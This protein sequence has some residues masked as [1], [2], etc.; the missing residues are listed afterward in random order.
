MQKD[1]NFYN[2]VRE[3]LNGL[4][5]STGHQLD[6]W[7]T[8]YAI[9]DAVH[10]NIDP[11]MSAVVRTEH[12]IAPQMLV[13]LRE[14]VN[15]AP[16]IPPDMGGGENLFITFTAESAQFQG[17]N[18]TAFG[19]FYTRLPDS[20]EEIEEL[21]S[22][23]FVPGKVVTAAY[24]LIV[25]LRAPSGDVSLAATSVI[26]GLDENGR[27]IAYQAY[28]FNPGMTL[29]PHPPSSMS[30]ADPNVMLYIFLTLSV[31]MMVHQGE[32]IIHWE[33]DNFAVIG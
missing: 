13:D 27:L 31:F 23:I 28:Q 21:D 8:G 24:R 2:L 16:P 9:G 11:A 5:L 29:T 18:A 26:L 33:N 30:D 17:G 25:F 22:G 10:L 7:L 20:A 4:F 19:I 1:D 3:L 6:L 14:L 12:R 15:V 32:T